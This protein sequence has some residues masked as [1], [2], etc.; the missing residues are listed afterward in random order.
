MIR[1]AALLLALAACSGTATPTT[2]ATTVAADASDVATAADT[3]ASIAGDLQ[4]IAD[5]PGLT[6]AQIA[7]LQAAVAKLQAIQLPPSAT[8]TELSTGLATVQAIL[9]DVGAVLPD[10]LPLLTL[11]H[12]A[13]AVPVW[14][15]GETPRIA[16]ARLRAL[17]AH[18]AQLRAAAKHAAVV[19]QKP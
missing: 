4:Q 11:I 16:P 10:V 12:G 17:A 1:P 15:I 3:I 7:A 2:V 8:A 14:L 18:L 5:T 13:H 19:Q 9:G 6:V